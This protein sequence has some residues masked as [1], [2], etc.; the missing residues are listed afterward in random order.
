MRDDGV[1][2]VSLNI[3]YEDRLTRPLHYSAANQSS[4]PA[5]EAGFWMN[6]GT[7]E[8]ELEI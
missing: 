2:R 6:E 7:K 8:R 4:C 1:V 3:F 5:A